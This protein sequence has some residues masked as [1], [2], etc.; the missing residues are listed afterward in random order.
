MGL[1]PPTTPPAVKSS[2]AGHLINRPGSPRTNRRTSIPTTKRSTRTSL[3]NYTFFNRRLKKP[4]LRPRKPKLN[5]QRLTRISKPRT[6]QA[7]PKAKESSKVSKR[8]SA[9][10]LKKSSSKKALATALPLAPTVSRMQVA[11]KT[12]R[13]NVHQK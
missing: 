2:T 5:G 13:Q 6:M 11:E 12:I 3:A 9:K 8:Q 7:L 4:R 10:T 1:I